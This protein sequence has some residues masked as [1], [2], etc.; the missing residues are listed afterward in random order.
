MV[1]LSQIERATGTSA[2][3]NLKF[4]WDRV[5]VSYI[6]FLAIFS[7]AVYLALTESN[8][9]VVVTVSI[10]SIFAALTVVVLNVVLHQAIRAVRPDKFSLG[11][12]PAVAAFLFFSP[13]EAALIIAGFNL[14]VGVGAMRERRR[15]DSLQMTHMNLRRRADSRR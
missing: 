13:F 2:L 8:Q 1:P 9:A 15:Y 7:A 11:V 3:Q 10:L 6:A 5:L 14:V 4:Q 12:L